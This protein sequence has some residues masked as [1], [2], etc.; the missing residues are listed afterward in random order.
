[1]QQM[2]ARLLAEMDAIRGKT[3]ADREERKEEMKAN[4]EEM[5]TFVSRMDILVHQE[6]REAAIHSLRA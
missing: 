4:Q 5:K 6:K 2:M 3:D 1:M